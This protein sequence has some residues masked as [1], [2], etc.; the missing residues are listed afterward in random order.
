MG[1]TS[2]G[3]HGVALHGAYPRR[4]KARLLKSVHLERLTPPYLYRGFPVQRVLLETSLHFILS[5]FRSAAFA[6]SRQQQD[7]SSVLSHLLCLFRIIADRLYH[8]S[9]PHSRIL[10]FV[11]RRSTCH[12]E[13]TILSP[14]PNYA[15]S[16]FRLCQVLLIPRQL[17]ALT[18]RTIWR[19]VSISKW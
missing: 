10:S 7:S 12:S 13:A 11:S 5:P 9:R 1:E 2:T 17:E 18:D 8:P 19:M 3:R 15:L 4:T 6:D 16:G 14:A